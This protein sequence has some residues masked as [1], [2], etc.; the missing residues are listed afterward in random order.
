SLGNRRVAVSDRDLRE[1]RDDPRPPPT[2]RPEP[3]SVLA[4]RVIPGRARFVNSGPKSGGD[5]FRGTDQRYQVRPQDDVQRALQPPP[6]NHA[7][8]DTV[9]GVSVNG[10]APS[11][12]TRE[13]ARDLVRD[14]E[15]VEVMRA[16]ETRTPG[17]ARRVDTQQPPV[18]SFRDTPRD[19]T[20][21]E[22]T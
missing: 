9:R 13:L 17:N 16:E 1:W 10:M 14:R 4:G 11:Q 5:Y 22:V 15:H 18:Q 19:A 2:I 7:V 21:R 8:N 3:S 12:R 20:P 6:R